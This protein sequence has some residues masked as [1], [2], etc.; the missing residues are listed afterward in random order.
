MLAVGERRALSMAGG[1]DSPHTGDSGGAWLGWQ[2]EFLSAEFS[3]PLQG[4][5]KL[6]ALPLIMSFKDLIGLR[7]FKRKRWTRRNLKDLSS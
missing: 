5:K 6:D 4:L 7:L 2:K 1:G 3:N